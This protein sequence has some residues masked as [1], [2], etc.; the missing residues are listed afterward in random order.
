MLRRQEVVFSKMAHSLDEGMDD[1]MHDGTF[2]NLLCFD[3][4]MNFG[5]IRKRDF[6]EFVKLIENKVLTEW[7][8]Q[9]E[10]INWLENKAREELK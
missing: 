8:G 1:E 3:K 4:F 6:I 10:F 9:N 7:R 2:C 5:S